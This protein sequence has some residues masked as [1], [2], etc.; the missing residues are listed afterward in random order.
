MRDIGARG[1]DALPVTVAADGEVSVGPEP[2]GHLSGFEFRVD[3]S[4]RLADKRLL[5]AAA[6]RRLGDELDRRAT[7]LVEA[8]DE[9]FEL[10][11]EDNGSLAVSWDGHV[12]ARL[13]PGRSLLEPAL[14]T[15]RALDRLSAQSRGALRERLERWLD[16]QVARHLRPLKVARVRS[17][18]PGELTRRARP[19][20]D[21]DGC[22]RAAS[23]ARRCSAQFRTSSRPTAKRCTGCASVW[24]RSTSSFHSC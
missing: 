11:A 10:I 18:R 12:L 14:R 15:A 4:A 23:R 6:E 7:A 19:R 5:L 21:A 1:A 20:C 22:R 3:P 13:A 2:I 24:G 16:A 9:A 17:D 8:A